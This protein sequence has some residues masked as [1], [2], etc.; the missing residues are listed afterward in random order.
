MF[1]AGLNKFARRCLDG[2]N[3][4]KHSH[5]VISSSTEIAQLFTSQLL[6]QLKYL[7]F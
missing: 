1:E 7:T 2:V 5:P 6:H 4:R 3:K